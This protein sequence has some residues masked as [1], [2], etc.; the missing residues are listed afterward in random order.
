MDN[1]ADFTPEELKEYFAVLGEPGYRAAQVFSWIHRGVPSFSQMTNLPKALR[2]RLAEVSTPC[3]AEIFESFHSEIDETVKYLIKLEDGNFVESVRMSYHHGATVCLS[4]QVGCRMGCGF[5][6]STIGG[7][8]RPLSPGEMVAQVALVSAAGEEPVSNIVLMGIGEPLDNYDN[9]L[10]FIRLVNDETG[11]N[12]GQRHISVSTCGLVD[13]IDRLAGE[14]LGITLCISLHAAEDEKRNQIMPV[15]R[16]YPLGGLIPA[17]R[18][19]VDRTRRRII[20]EYA[21]I[22]NFNDTEEDAEK[23]SRL[24]RGMTC[25]VNLIPVN[26]VR[27]RDFQRS[28]RAAWFCKQLER[29]NISATVRRELGSD[30]DASCGQLRRRRMEKEKEDC[31]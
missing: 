20:F 7:L 18:R 27:E 5:C 21:L 4:T 12:I 6:A 14:D 25:H 29:R 19:Y 15:N 24:L 1:L 23:L 26:P 11:L 13:G 10:K 22:R 9:V 8:V 2:A 3:G 31:L 30:I 28:T 16:R 17:C